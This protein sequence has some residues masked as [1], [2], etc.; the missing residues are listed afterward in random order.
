[1]NSIRF[2]DE[3]DFIRSNYANMSIKDLA[4]ELGRSQTFVRKYANKFGLKKS[5]DFYHNQKEKDANVRFVVFC[6]SK[7]EIA[8]YGKDVA[9]HLGVHVSQITI[10][11]HRREPLKGK[12]NV[13]YAS[14]SKRIAYIKSHPTEV[15]TETMDWPLWFFKEGIAP[16]Y[17]KYY[18]SKQMADY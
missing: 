7:V 9:E 14:D 18:S 16:I 4:N 12:Y 3:I 10:A 5:D 2:K 1:M 13:L 17:A 6:G 8:G 11:A 15:K